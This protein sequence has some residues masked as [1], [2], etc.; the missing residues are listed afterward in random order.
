MRRSLKMSAVAFGAL[1]LIPFLAACGD[2]SDSDSASDSGSDST[3]EVSDAWARPA[4]DGDNTGVYLTI[5]GGD[6]D[7]AL[8]GV[9]ADNV[10]D[11]VEIHE[12]VSGED[13][14]DM[15]SEDMD[16]EDTDSGATDEMDSDEMDSDEMD[17]DDSGHS[18]EEAGAIDDSVNE[19]M[20]DTDSGGMMS[21]RPVDS[22]AVPAGET[23]ALEPGGFHVMLTG[24]KEALEVGDTFEIVL[25]FESGKQ[26][27]TSVEVRE[28]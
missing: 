17:T 14:E 15:D 24:L 9:E 1:L 7:D 5:T 19:E 3:V 20:D 12:T 11:L 2:D 23:V 16:S 6:M 4:A 22:I 26:V 13:S 28:S 27:T 10:A 21:M 8:V 25:D 18:D